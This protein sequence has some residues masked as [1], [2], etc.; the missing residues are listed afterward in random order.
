MAGQFGHAR[1]DVGVGNGLAEADGQRIVFVG[2]RLQR[3]VDEQVTR[4]GSHGGQH[5][6]VLDP[7]FAQAFDHA[8]TRTRRRHADTGAR[9]QG[10]SHDFTSSIWPKRVRSICSGVIDTRPFATAKKSVPSPASCAAPAA[11]TQ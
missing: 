6:L 8:A 1:N 11:P 10:F 9:V 7:L 3:L 5:D 4:H 2:P